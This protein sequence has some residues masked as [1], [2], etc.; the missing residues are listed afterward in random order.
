M[1]GVILTLVAALTYAAALFN[2]Y[3]MPSS[4][5]GILLAVLINTRMGMIINI[6]MALL[7]GLLSGMQI[8]PVAMTMVGGMVGISMLKS[9]QQ[10]NSLVWAGIGIAGGNLLT[11]TAYEMLIQSGWLGPL[12]ALSG[13]FWPGLWLDSDHWYI[14]HLGK[15]L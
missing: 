11:I 15:C 6:V 5:A 1:T 14:T 7:A 8:A 10:R 2:P 3:L 12:P 9:I 13:A 4:M